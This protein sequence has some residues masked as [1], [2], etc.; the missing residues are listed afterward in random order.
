MLR[1]LKNKLHKIEIS[2][3]MKLIA[4]F[5][6]MTVVLFGVNV[7]IYSNLDEMMLQIEQVYA[8]NTELNELQ[9]I[10]TLVQ[11]DMTEYLNLRQ[12]DSMENFYRDVTEYDKLVEGLNNQIT[13][14]ELLL[15]EKN[16]RNLSERYRKVSEAWQSSTGVV[17]MLRNIKRIMKK[18]RN[19]A[20]ISGTTSIA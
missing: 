3:Q 1:R 6:I 8:S 2:I 9:N 16:I 7:Y 11:D 10:L 5:L 15:L 13:D 19:C 17:I 12:T 20:R 4:V 14:D 18:Q